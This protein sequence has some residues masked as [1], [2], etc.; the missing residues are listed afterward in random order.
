MGY[1]TIV[2]GTDGSPTAQRAVERA[3]RL[4]KLLS[5]KLV[6]VCAWSHE[7]VA[8]LDAEPTVQSAKAAVATALG[9]AAD[10]VTVHGEPG[11]SLSATA[12]ERGADLIVVGSVG[13]GQVKR[14][15]LGGVAERAAH[16]APCDVLIVRTGGAE[17]GPVRRRVYQGIVTGTNG[18]ATASEAVRRAFDLG[19]MFETK[20]TVVYVAGD[21]LVGA[22]SLERALAAKPKW[23]PV[24]TLL[25]RGGDPAAMIAEVARTGGG[26]LV[27][28]G[29]KGVVGARRWMLSSV[30]VKL[31]HE[32]SQD[33]LIAKTTDRSLEDLGPGQGGLVTVDGRK[34]AVFVEENGKVHSLSPRCQHMGCT[35]DW[36]GADRTWDCPCHGSRYR[37]DGEVIH[38]P[39]RKALD[40][41][42]PG[43]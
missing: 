23:V 36:N 16:T 22:I 11:A 24:E 32:A 26:E 33:V 6:L 41:T 19:M 27:V 4:A 31:A 29:N 15:R 1:R 9:V 7:G 3:A 28:V 8:E 40:R 5:S 43:A 13:M 2:A 38:G 30:P 42:E 37:Y 10:A 17:A 35:V 39:A 18:S 14:F 20:V 12:A 34:L 25:V 21:P